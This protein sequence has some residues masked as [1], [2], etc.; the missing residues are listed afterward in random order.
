MNVISLPESAFTYQLTDEET[1]S[2]WNGMEIKL[3]NSIHF[4]AFLTIFAW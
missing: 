3:Y 2:L 4:Y 1:T